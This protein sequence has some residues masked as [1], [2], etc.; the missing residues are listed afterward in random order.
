VSRLGDLAFGDDSQPAGERLGVRELVCDEDRR[1]PSFG[2]KIRD[3]RG[4]SPS[5]GGVQ[6]G[7]RLVE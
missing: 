6:A 1:H 2:A 7:E 3:K 4:E 5:E